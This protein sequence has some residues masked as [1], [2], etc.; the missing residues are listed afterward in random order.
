MSTAPPVFDLDYPDDSWTCPITGAGP[1]PKTLDHFELLRAFTDD[2]VLDIVHQ[3]A[4][5][6][7]YSTHEFGDSL[8][9]DRRSAA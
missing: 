2:P 1:V 4:T 7:R 5:E 9:I 8:L 3:T 6:R